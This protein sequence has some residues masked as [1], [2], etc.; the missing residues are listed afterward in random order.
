MKLVRQ[1]QHVSS[2]SS[3][4]EPY[5]ASF[6]PFKYRPRIPIRTILVFY[7]QMDIPNSALFPIQAPSIL[8]R[9]V[10]PTRDQQ[11]GVR[12]SFVQEEPLDLRY[13]PK[14]LAIC[15]VEGV[16]K[17]LDILSSEF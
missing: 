1:D 3:T 11:V 14:M 12:T 6:Q 16:S 13:L 10:I 17:Y 8:P 4:W 7:E 9:T 5:S 15:V 2:I